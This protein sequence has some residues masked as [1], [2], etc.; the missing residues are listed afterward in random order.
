MLRWL[1]DQEELLGP[2]SCPGLETG[3]DEV[4]GLSMVDCCDSCHVDN[5]RV[6]TTG[7][8]A[9][10]RLGFPFHEHKKVGIKAAMFNPFM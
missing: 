1:L 7:C 10:D 8:P 6:R 5:G 9:K 2:I 3:S 4:M